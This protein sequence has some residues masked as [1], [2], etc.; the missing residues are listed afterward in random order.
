ME[1][2]VTTFKGLTPRTERLT[3]DGREETRRDLGPRRSKDRLEVDGILPG[4]SR[5]RDH[6][7]NRLRGVFLRIGV[8]ST[9]GDE[10]L[11]GRLVTCRE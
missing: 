11:L 4:A 1:V 2:S 3:V 5:V 6:D 10:A 7:R 8:D 9:A